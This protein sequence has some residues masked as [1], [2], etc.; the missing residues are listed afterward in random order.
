MS[1]GQTMR[2]FGRQATALF[3][4]LVVWPFTIYRDQVG[5]VWSEGPTDCT[6]PSVRLQEDYDTSSLLCDGGNV[7]SCHAVLADVI[8]FVS[9]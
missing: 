8:L 2:A 4:D 3:D 1:L 7:M 5:R 6:A 9:T